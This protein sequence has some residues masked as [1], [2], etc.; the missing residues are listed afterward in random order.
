MATKFVYSGA[1]GS[2]TGAD[3]TNAYT[4]L[5]SAASV[6]AGDIVKVHKTHSQTGL[7]AD[8]N[9]SNGTAVAPVLVYCV[10]KDNSDALSTGASVS[11]GTADHGIAGN[12]ISYGVNYT[13]A[14]GSFT[15]IVPAA[16]V[17]TLE[18]CTLTASTGG[19][20]N[21]PITQ[22]GDLYFH[23]VNVDLSSSG[24][25]SFAYIKWGDG[26]TRVGRFEWRGGTYTC[27]TGQSTLLRTENVANMCIDIAGVLF[28]GTVTNLYELVTTQAA[29]IRLADC[30]LPTYT[31]VFGTA[32]SI[33]STQ[34][35]LERCAAS[36][37]ITVSP[38]SKFATKLGTITQDTA[39]YRTGGADD[40]VQANA[41]SWAMV[42]N[43]S[44]GA[45]TLPMRSPPITE[46]TTAG[47]QTLTVY[48]AGGASLNNDDVWLEVTSQSEAGSATAQGKFQTT[49]PN[50][51]A[52]NA[53]LTTDGTSTWNGSG[54]GT[55]QKITATIAPTLAGPVSV[56]VCLA[57]ASTTLY[58]DPQIVIG[59]V[60]GKSRFMEGVQAFDIADSGGGGGTAGGYIIGG[61]G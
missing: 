60:T 4:S 43:S 9:F 24:A 44:S 47:S 18:N 55:K 39:H 42:T 10:D 27:K 21:L 30:V 5:A 22:N 53:A 17:M 33:A 3:W 52:S 59:S 32:P 54:V 36:G 16:G 49:R 50:P 2:N 1:A 13:N 28:S 34:V 57:K 23:N 45:F 35:I 46:W 7:S 41:Y 40:G 14:A 51:L 11:W 20:A 19:F 8:I 29:T 58:V 38:L 15:I 12:F 56:R 6:A 48:A 37:T 31:N 61:A 26:G 25:T